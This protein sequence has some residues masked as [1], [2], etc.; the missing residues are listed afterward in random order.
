[1]DC[2]FCKIVSGEIPS[3]KVYEDSSTLAFL[4]INPVSRGHTVVLPKVHTGSFTEMVPDNAGLLFAAVNRVMKA[5]LKTLG[6]PAA[7]V[8]L[9]NGEIA[10]Q[11]VPHV[12]VHIIPR[13]ENDGGG[14]MH[15]IVDGEAD[16]GEL[17]E[18]AA[19]IAGNAR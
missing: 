16:T 10:G 19:L 1:M 14:S 11:S 6:A 18:L 4:D 15:T 12:H 9:N 17:E 7:N 8:G 5:V 13:Y 2:L 3:Y